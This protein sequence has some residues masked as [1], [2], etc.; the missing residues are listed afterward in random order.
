MD[1]GKLLD[2][3]LGEGREGCASID[4]GWG[5]AERRKGERRGRVGIKYMVMTAERRKV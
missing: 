4:R 5:G 3:Y 2:F 1:P